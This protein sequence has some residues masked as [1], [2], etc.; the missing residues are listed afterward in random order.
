MKF[1]QTDSNFQDL[2][3]TN[4][5]YEPLTTRIFQVKKAT[6]LIQ[7]K[8]QS[9][10]KKRLEDCSLPINDKVNWTAAYLLPKKSTKLIEFQF[11]F[12]RRRVP[13]N[14][15]FRFCHTYSES[16]IHLFW[17]CRQT[18]HIW[19]K[20]TEW[21]RNLNLLP[22]DYAVTNVTALRLRPDISQFGLLI[23]YCFLLAWYHIWLTTTKEDRPNLTHFL[24]TIKSQ[25]EIKSGD[26]KKW[27]PLAGYMRI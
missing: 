7:K 14:N 13:T 24:C 2:K 3:N 15:F 5:E 22:R 10:Q 9:S 17:S 11:K 6:T 1:L 25:Y 19:N 27:K 8:N 16:L 21:L 12:L 23:N 4:F 20:V 18:S 26:T